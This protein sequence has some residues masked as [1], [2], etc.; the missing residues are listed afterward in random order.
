MYE[1]WRNKREIKKGDKVSLVD[2]QYLPGELDEV[3][4]YGLF[5]VIDLGAASITIFN[6]TEN[7]LFTIDT[8]CVF[9]VYS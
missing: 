2:C 6:K 7:E 5:E 1:I 3:G 9:E 4:H 8:R